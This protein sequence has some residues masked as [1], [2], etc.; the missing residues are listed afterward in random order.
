M[1]R[2]SIE[3]EVEGR[4]A[5]AAATS[6]AP[7][8]SSKYMSPPSGTSTTPPF[9]AEGGLGR[10]RALLLL[11]PMAFEVE[12]A[13]VVSSQVAGTERYADRGSAS[14]P[15]QVEDEGGSVGPG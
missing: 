12:V 10:E 5:V 6:A 3:A 13:H 2:A 11:P 9:K 1:M 8:V 14:R 4:R 15:T 7:G